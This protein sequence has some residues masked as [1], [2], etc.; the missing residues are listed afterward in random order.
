MA[1][2]G[3]RTFAA[4]EVLTAS[5]VMGYLQDQAVMNFAGTA[6]RGSAISAPDEGMISY[7]KDTDAI[8]VY[9]TAWQNIL[10]SATSLGASGS[11]G[12]V[13]FRNGIIIQW[14]TTAAGGASSALTFTFPIAF[15]TAILTAQGIV[16]ASAGFGGKGTSLDTFNQTSVTMAHDIG[17][18][19]SI[20]VLVIGY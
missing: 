2:L 17:A 10:F 15:P 7:L 18:T 12:Y 19:T 1:G 14:G 20:R 4:G 8:E 13:R 11:S 9:T 5:N 16:S 3:R 6:A